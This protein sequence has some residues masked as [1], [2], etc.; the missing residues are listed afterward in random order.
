[1][2]IHAWEMCQQA[3]LKAYVSP[4]EWKTMMGGEEAWRNMKPI[5]TPRPRKWQV[6]KL[7]FI[8]KNTKLDIKSMRGFLFTPDMKESLILC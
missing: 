3:G 7:L 1:M 2:W 5:N 4:E 8:I 6:N